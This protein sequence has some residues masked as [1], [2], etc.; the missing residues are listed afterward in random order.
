MYDVAGQLRTA[1]RVLLLVVDPLRP[2]TPS[3]LRSSRPATSAREQAIRASRSF[4]RPVQLL[5]S[6]NTSH[7]QRAIFWGWELGST[8]DLKNDSLLR[9]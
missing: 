8:H 5:S 1:E 4:G 6:H 3:V 2:P 7:P 9:Q